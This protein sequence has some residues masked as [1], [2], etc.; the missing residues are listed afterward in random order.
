MPRD[1]KYPNGSR[2][3]RAAGTGY[4]KATGPQRLIRTGPSE[5]YPLVG[6]RRTLVFYTGPDEA[7]MTAWT[8]YE[9]ENH[10]S[11][12]EAND[13]HIDKVIHLNGVFPL[14]YFVS[15]SLHRVS[16]CACV[17]DRPTMII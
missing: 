12:A 2:P 16:V 1:R 7:A 17:S 9:Y 4:W 13:K 3:N 11:E 6:R 15:S 10:T 8:M 5:A 14:I